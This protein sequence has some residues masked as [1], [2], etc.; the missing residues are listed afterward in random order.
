MEISI[1]SYVLQLADKYY[2]DRLDIAEPMIWIAISYARKRQ[3][4]VIRSSSEEEFI[5]GALCLKS[6]CP[7]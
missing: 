1:L 2:W 3:G 5:A 4:E 6:V 7:P